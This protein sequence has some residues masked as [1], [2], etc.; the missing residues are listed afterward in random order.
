LAINIP[1]IVKAATA[2]TS[3]ARLIQTEARLGEKALQAE[4]G[5]EAAKPIPAALFPV[6]NTLR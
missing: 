6:V 3:S 4:G 5:D 1:A 2:T